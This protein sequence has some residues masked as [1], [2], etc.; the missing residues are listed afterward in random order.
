MQARRRTTAS[1]FTLVELLV[2]I[3]IIAVLIALLLPAV[4]GARES[5]RRTQCGN[6]L[7]QIGV[8]LQAYHT[9]NSR[10]P[11]GAFYSSTEPGVSGVVAN[12]PMTWASAIL[13]QLEAL[14]HYDA[15][16]FARVMSDAA[17]LTAVTTAVPGYICPSDPEGSQPIRDDRCRLT[18]AYAQRHMALWYPGSVGPVWPGAAC[19]FC[20]NTAS[21]SGNPCCQGSNYGQ[22][23]DGPGV[24]VRWAVPIT[25]DHV[26]DGLSNTIL[27]GEA[28]PGENLHNMAFGPNMPLAATNIPINT[29]ATP[30]EQLLPGMDDSQRHAANRHQRMQGY[31]SRHVGA[32]GFLRADGSMTFVDETVEPQILWA[33]G[34]KAGRESLTLP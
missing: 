28:L 34:T 22:N 8:A 31:K 4:Q 33:M 2:V 9:A 1:G 5:A 14:P 7:K 18:S 23:G 3:A 32:C 12:S 11:A 16:N 15:F 25:F 24:F 30:S 27:A 20:T 17:N 19:M 6:N 21:S 10:L 29:F 26:R 13:P